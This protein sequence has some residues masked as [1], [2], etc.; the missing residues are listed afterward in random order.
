VFIDPS[1]QKK[2]SMA[3]LHISDYSI[4]E[5]WDIR[6]WPSFTMLRGK[7]MVEGGQLVG[8]LGDGQLIPRKIDSTVLNRPAI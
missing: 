4:W 7:I 6:G 2:L 5:G 3:D 1:I 8:K